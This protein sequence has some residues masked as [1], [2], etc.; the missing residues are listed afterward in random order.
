[1][2]FVYFLPNKKPAT[3]LEIFERFKERVELHFH[4][5]GYKIKSVRM[6]D[7]SEYQVTLKDFLIEKGIESDITAHYSPESNGISER[8]NRTLLDM[9]RIMLFNVNLS[10]KL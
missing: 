4:S 8:L 3:V 2:S 10:N 7:G 1:M 5:K 6:N 9:A